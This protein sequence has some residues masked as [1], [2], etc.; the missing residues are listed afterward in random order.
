MGSNTA[1]GGPSLVKSSTRL[2]MSGLRL[3]IESSLRW[4][5]SS[6]KIKW[7]PLV[8]FLLKMLNAILM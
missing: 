3:R 7:R 8:Y 2:L 1:G 5:A 4:L 6:T